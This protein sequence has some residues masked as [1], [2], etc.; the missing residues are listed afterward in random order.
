MF[1]KN[2]KERRDRKKIIDEIIY[3]YLSDNFKFTL[4]KLCV[5]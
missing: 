5:I 1:V 3:V 2:E 4:I